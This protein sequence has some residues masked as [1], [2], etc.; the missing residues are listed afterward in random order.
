M[1]LIFL[2]ALNKENNPVQFSFHADHLD[3]LYKSDKILKAFDKRFGSEYIAGGLSY[4]RLKGKEIK[5]QLISKD[6]T[7]RF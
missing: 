1:T 5:T 2:E 6:G 3:I 4:V 7:F